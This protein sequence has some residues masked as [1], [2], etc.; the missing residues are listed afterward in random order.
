MSS[1]NCKGFDRTG[2]WGVRACCKRVRARKLG[3][4]EPRKPYLGAWIF[5]PYKVTRNLKRDNMIG[6]IN[7]P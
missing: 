2:V 3:R 7:H 6:F 5:F 1:R 4:V